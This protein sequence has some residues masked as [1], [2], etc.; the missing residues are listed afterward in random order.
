MKVKFLKVK[1]TWREVTDAELSATVSNYTTTWIAANGEA[2]R[3]VAGMGGYM[4]VHEK[5]EML[6]QQ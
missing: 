4:A 3:L 5:K 2:G 1:G 6:C